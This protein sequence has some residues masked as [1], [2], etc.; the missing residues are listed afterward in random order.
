MKR[1]ALD[2]EVTGVEPS[3]GHR[4][5]AVAACEL[6]EDGA[7]VNEFQA[8]YNPEM[9]IAPLEKLIGRTDADLMSCPTFAEA[10]GEFLEFIRD[11]E[12]IIHYAD[13]DVGFINNEI[14]LAF[15]E[16]P[17]L[18]KHCLGIVDTRDLYSAF[19]PQQPRSI[20]HACRSMGID[21]ENYENRPIES[22]Y[23]RLTVKL[24][25]ALVSQQGGK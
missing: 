25:H 16:H 3:E 1:I 9:S 7:V 14:E 20:E 10:G 12:L 22:H 17:L 19:F 23:A 4:M 24:Y 2:I 11:A 5:I 18:G 21:T 8:S 6:G 13:F 15:P